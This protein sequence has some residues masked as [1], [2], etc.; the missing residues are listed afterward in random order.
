MEKLFIEE[1]RGE[2]ELAKHISLSQ[3]DPAAL[4]ELKATGLF[5]NANLYVEKSSGGFIPI[6]IGMAFCKNQIFQL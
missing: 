4:I 2:L 1:N 3:P 6:A 5:M